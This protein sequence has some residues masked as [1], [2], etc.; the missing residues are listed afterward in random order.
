[1]NSNIPGSP[2]L[3]SPTSVEEA[4]ELYPSEMNQVKEITAAL[5]RKYGGT[6]MTESNQ[7]QFGNE[8]IDRFADIGL[9]LSV[10]WAGMDVDDST[11]NLYYIPQFT[12]EGR[13]S[14]E[15]ETDHERLQ[16][17]ITSGE[18]DGRPGYIR[19]DGKIHEDPISK[20]IL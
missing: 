10:S 7:L 20:L 15:K 16:T 19:E 14:Q 3:T 4:F 11:D 8:A 5:Q 17:E 6:A 12:I 9:R 13:L 2:P 1:M 18:L